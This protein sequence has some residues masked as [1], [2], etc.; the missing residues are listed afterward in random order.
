MANPHFPPLE[1]E[2]VAAQASDAKRP[3]R[4]GRIGLRS[5][6]KVAESA[7]SASAPSGGICET[8]E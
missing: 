1:K 4:N 8:R 7:H 5:H 6:L 2:S 3:K